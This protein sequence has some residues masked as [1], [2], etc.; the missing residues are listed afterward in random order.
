VGEVY[1]QLFE[2]P[3]TAFRLLRQTRALAVSVFATKVLH[4]ALVRL[5][6][7]VYHNSFPSR[8]HGYRYQE[9]TT[10]L[11][12][13]ARNVEGDIDKKDADNP[14]EVL[15]YSLKNMGVTGTIRAVGLIFTC[16]RGRI[17]LTEL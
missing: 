13:P 4:R 12:L 1:Q 7:N 6:R 14:L 5:D 10:A 17:L 8:Y 3:L 9:T 2:H 16:W 11:L 15:E